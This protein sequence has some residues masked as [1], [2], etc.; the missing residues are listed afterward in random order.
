[1]S[2]YFRKSEKTRFSYVSF[3]SLQNIVGTVLQNTVL[4]PS[5]NIL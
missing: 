5:E 4:Q 2:K 1:M 3:S